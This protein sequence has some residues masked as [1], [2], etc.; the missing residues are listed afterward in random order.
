MPVARGDGEERCKGGTLTFSPDSETM[1]LTVEGRFEGEREEEVGKGGRRSGYCRHHRERMQHVSAAIQNREL[2]TMA[3]RHQRREAGRCSH[4][5]NACRGPCPFPFFR[6]DLAPSPLT[7]DPPERPRRHCICRDPESIAWQ[8]RIE[9]RERSGDGE[10]DGRRV[11]G[12]RV[13]RIQRRGE[14]G[15]EVVALLDCGLM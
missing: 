10:C 2:E 7:R 12:A 4:C 5:C 13:E 14:R 15:Q 6:Q 9:P 3:A 8:L 1:L 11:D